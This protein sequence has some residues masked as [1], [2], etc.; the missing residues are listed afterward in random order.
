MEAALKDGHLGEVLAQGKRLPPKAAL[1]AD[2]WL[3]KLEAR[4]AADQAVAGIESALKVSLSPQ[5]PPEAKR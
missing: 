5:G 2:G 3:R 1:A 4:Y